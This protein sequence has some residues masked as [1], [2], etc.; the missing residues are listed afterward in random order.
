MVRMRC[1][2]RSAWQRSSNCNTV[3]TLHALPYTAHLTP[4][5]FKVNIHLIHQHTK[6]Y[7]NA[8]HYILRED[9]KIKYVA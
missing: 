8:L 4:Y 1:V 7:I 2:V 3:T 9:F 6:L 5:T